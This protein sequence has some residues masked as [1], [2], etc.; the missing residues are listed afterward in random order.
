M[1]D[2]VKLKQTNKTLKMTCY[3]LLTNS[4]IPCEKNFRFSE[5]FTSSHSFL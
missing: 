5:I 2:Q 1:P 3:D 4:F